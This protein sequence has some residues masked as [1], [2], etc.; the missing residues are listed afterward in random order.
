MHLLRWLAP[1]AILLALF[2]G[3]SY[4]VKSSK[5]FPDGLTQ[6]ENVQHRHCCAFDTPPGSHW[7]I[8]PYA[9]RVQE[10]VQ[11][12][13]SVPEAQM[14]LHEKGWVSVRFV[15]NKDGTIT[16]A[17]IKHYSDIEPFDE[18]A[19]EAI[20]WSSPLPSLPPQVKAPQVKAI[21]RFFYN[22]KGCK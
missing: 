20:L 13:W 8:G 18:A 2:V 6:Q 22:M 4:A 17:A 21:F 9:K 11:R 16:N 10:K 19:L 3:C 1:V 14:V 7:D 5:S 15:I 12:H